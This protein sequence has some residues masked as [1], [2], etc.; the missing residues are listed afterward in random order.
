MARGLLI[1]LAL[2]AASGVN[3]WEAIA[4]LPTA[5]S[6][7]AAVVWANSIYVPGGLGGTRSF[8][9]LDTAS[10]R[11]RALPP[12]P[13]GRH[14]PA[15]A[16]YD[17]KI[18][19]FGGADSRW[20]ASAASFVYDIARASW[21]HGKD[22]PAVRYAAAAVVIEPFIYVVGGDGPGGHTLRYDPARDHWTTLPP[23]LMRREHTGAV[24]RDG[25][26]IVAGGRWAGVGEL[27]SSEVFD[28][29]TRR[30]RQGPRLRTARGGFA[31]VDH[32]GRIYALG[33]EVMLSGSE[34]LASVERLDGDAWVPAAPLPRALHGVP[35]AS[36]GGFLYVLGGSR[37]AG[38]IVNDGAAFRSADY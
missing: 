26:I 24:A 25:Q 16:A 37:R 35:V 36:H 23:T 4:P 31:L 19:V 14:H 1:G 8:E 32:D 12:L 22:L 33:G 28:P 18:Y 7:T 38:A 27:D 11:W 3:A 17:G 21:R 15:V 5:R 30:W 9:A 10:G 20:R 34:T 13:E 6:E 2:L 29:T